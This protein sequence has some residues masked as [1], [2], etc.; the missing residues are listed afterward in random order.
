MEET[1][2]LELV[3]KFEGKSVNSLMGYTK[4]I[5]MFVCNV[6]PQMYK[7]ARLPIIYFF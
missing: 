7:T 2:R 4:I 6:R 3:E 5:V 1:E